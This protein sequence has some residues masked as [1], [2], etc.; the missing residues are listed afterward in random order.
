MLADGHAE[1]LPLAG[2]T[3]AG[4]EGRPNQPHCAGSH[5]IAAAVKGAHGNLETLAF[6]AEAIFHRHFHILKGNPAGGTGA[7]AEFAFDIAA[8][9]AGRMQVHDESGKPAVRFLGFRIGAGRHDGIIGQR[10]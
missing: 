4:I 7:H 1:G 3:H 10:G 6:L 9:D 8:L 5:G 2:V